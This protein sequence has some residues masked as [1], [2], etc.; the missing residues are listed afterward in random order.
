M[1]IMSEWLWSKVY[2]R[3]LWN[4]RTQEYDKVIHVHGW[5]SARVKTKWGGVYT[6]TPC[7]KILWITFD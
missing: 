1:K 7:F 5:R 3:W 2:K 4:I 6:I